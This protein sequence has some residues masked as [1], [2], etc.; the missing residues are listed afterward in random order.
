MINKFTFTMQCK[1]SSHKCTPHI[2]AI[3][4]INENIQ[5]T[6]EATPHNTTYW[7]ERYA[8]LNAEMTRL[9]GGEPRNTADLRE[10]R[11]RPLLSA[12]KTIPLSIPPTKG[13]ITEFRSEVVPQF[14]VRTK[15]GERST[16]EVDYL[17]Y[18]RR[19]HDEGRQ[20][21]LYLLPVE[22]R[23]EIE[24]IHY[25][26]LAWHMMRL[27][28]H[29]DFKKRMLVG[30]LIDKTS[31]VVCFSAF[32]HKTRRNVFAPT[33]L[34]WPVI[35]TT[36]RLQWMRDSHLDMRV[37][38]FLGVLL[39]CQLGLVRVKYHRVQRPTGLSSRE[40]QLYTEVARELEHNEEGCPYIPLGCRQFPV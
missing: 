2:K 9:G 16:C 24:I 32:R 11:V 37:F 28:T 7:R 27:G 8:T 10:K 30:L 34:P 18:G 33:K 4:H 1:P 3:D 26:Q 17:L 5:T 6:F 35:L 40:V 22:V 23:K 39:Q 13:H 38:V 20:E 21:L 12:L 15:A 31:V 29:S 36:P 14:L 19:Y 25:Y